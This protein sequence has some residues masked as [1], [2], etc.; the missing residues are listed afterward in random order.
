M[1]VAF[2][3]NFRNNNTV[4]ACDNINSDG[5][6]YR[7]NVISQVKWAVNDIMASSNRSSS[8]SD[9]HRI[10]QYGIV[11]AFTGQ[12]LYSAHGP[13]FESNPPNNSGVCR[14]F[15]NNTDKCGPLSDIPK[16]GVAWDCLNIF[17]DATN[18]DITFSAQLLEVY[19]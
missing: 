17:R 13:L 9:P 12:A 19:D 6:V 11:L 8:S 15:E 2:D 18:S 16:P 10:A 4:F 1:H 5:S 7:N 3:P 14:T